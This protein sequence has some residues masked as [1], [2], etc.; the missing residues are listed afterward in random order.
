[1]N[2]DKFADFSFVKEAF[3]FA[4]A[5]VKAAH[6]TNLQFY[7]ILFTGFYHFI[8]FLSVHCH[9]LFAEDVFSGIGAVDHDLTVQVCRRNDDDCVDV[10]IMED[11]VVICKIFGNA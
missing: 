3:G 11:I 8:A 7:V 1:M 5:A 6:K 2:L 9:R 4:K 10:C